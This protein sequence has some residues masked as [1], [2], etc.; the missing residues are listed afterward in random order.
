VKALDENP[1]VSSVKMTSRCRRKLAINFSLHCA[2]IPSI[3]EPTRLC[4]CVCVYQLRY[5]PYSPCNVNIELTS[6]QNRED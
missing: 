2:P 3:D 6:V 5:I 1:F 4:M